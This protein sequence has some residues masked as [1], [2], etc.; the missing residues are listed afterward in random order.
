MIQSFLCVVFAVCTLTAAPTALPPPASGAVVPGQLVAPPALDAQVVEVATPQVAANEGLPCE[1]DRCPAYLDR[2]A[3]PPVWTIC[4]GETRGVQ[5]GEVR[6]RAECMASLR[7]RVAEYWRGVRACMSETTLFRRMT[8]HR[9]GAFTDLG[10]N[11]GVAATCAATAMRRLNAGDI[12]GACVAISWFN[13]AGG[14][15]LIGLVNRRGRNQADCEL[16]LR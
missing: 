13:R 3:S 4:H 1:G 8:A 10:Y 15:M 6:T 2:L 16:G 12:E 11:V 5:P 9:G 14:R 7:P